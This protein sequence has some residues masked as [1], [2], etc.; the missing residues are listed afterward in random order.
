MVEVQEW[1]EIRHMKFVD[2]LSIR[3]IERRTVAFRLDNGVSYDTIA[4]FLS[5]A[6]GG[7]K[8]PIIRVAP[9]RYSIGTSH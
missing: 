2:R 9:G 1:A 3:E 5:V 8:W 4:S 6:A 7:D